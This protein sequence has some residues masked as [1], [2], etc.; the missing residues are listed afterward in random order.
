M[1]TDQLINY[2][3]NDLNYRGIVADSIE[4]ELIDHV[5][6]AVEEE[7]SKGEKFID[8]CDKVLK[9]FGHTGGLR[10]TQKRIDSNYKIK[11]LRI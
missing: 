2:M 5:C 9:S 7:M 4:D 3:I 11:R 8:A 1:L 6:S 10:E